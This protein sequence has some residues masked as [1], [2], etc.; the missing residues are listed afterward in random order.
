MVG[1][2]LVDPA[3]PLLVDVEVAGAMVER[4]VPV[5]A[6]WTKSFPSPVPATTTTTTENHI[7]RVNQKA[8]PMMMTTIGSW[9][10]IT[11]GIQ[12][13]TALL[14]R[15]GLDL[16]Q[17]TQSPP[18][19]K[20]MS[21]PTVMIAEAATDFSFREALQTPPIHIGTP[22]TTEEARAARAKVVLAEYGAAVD[23]TE[24]EDPAR[25]GT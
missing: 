24:R 13:K 17:K 23:L 16:A 12:V 11:A 8:R 18:N 3:Q 21:R 2:L 4:A 20:D 5:S 14:C 7:L 9:K 1:L 10:A 19:E 22:P 6:F 15:I 25:V